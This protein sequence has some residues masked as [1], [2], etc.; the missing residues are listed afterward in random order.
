MIFDR[1]RG[2]WIR[3]RRAGQLSAGMFAVVCVVASAQETGLDTKRLAQLVDSGDYRAA[4]AEAGALEEEARP[5]AK[6][7]TFVPRTRAMVELLLTRAVLQRR[8]GDLDAAE[9]S[10]G[11]AYKA[12]TDR[13][14]QRRLGLAVRAG[15]DQA[16][17]A[18]VPFE[19]VFVDLLDQGMG[20]VVDRLRQDGGSA[21]PEKLAGWLAQFEQLSKQAAAARQGLTERLEGAGAPL[22]QSPRARLLASDIELIKLQAMFA[23]AKTR[24][25]AADKDGGN[26]AGRGGATKVR[27]EVVKQLAQAVERAEEMLTAV[28]DSGAAQ[29]DAGGKVLLEANR[30]RVDLLVCL[31]EAQLFAGSADVAEETIDRARPLQKAMLDEMHPDRLQPTILAAGITEARRRAS[32]AAGRTFPARELAKRVATLAGEAKTL[33]EK[34]EKLFKESWPWRASL[35]AV[36]KNA[37]AAEVRKAQDPAVADAVDAA[38]QRVMP[39]IRS[40][41]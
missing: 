26:A 25:P 12:Y 7:N 21:E 32:E 23:L 8:I 11:V 36:A 29:D 14:F 3:G 5:K 22:A 40:L 13:E 18:L 20:L 1:A 39:L 19:L 30:I 33:L 2:G 41:P 38:T 17:A 28:A 6:D 35:A 37:P 27:A 10:L 4:I 24:L 31:A 16:A 9:E 34:H 15:G